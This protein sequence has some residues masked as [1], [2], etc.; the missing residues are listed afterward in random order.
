M[1]Q[2]LA[3]KRFHTAEQAAE[4]ISL[5]QEHDIPT[6]YEEEVVLLDK[7]YSGQNFD[8]RHLVKIPADYFSRA[9]ALLKSQITVSP[10]DVEPDYYLLS[11]STEELKEVII[12]KDEW[13][14]FD[15]ALALKLLEKQ[16]ISYSAEQLAHLGNSRLQTLSEP[17]DL[18]V[19]WLMIGYLSPLLLFVPL[20]YPYILSVMGI[21]IGAFV[22]LTKKTL[23]DGSRIQAFSAKT[24]N[25]GKWMILSGI[26]LTVICWALLIRLMRG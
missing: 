13:G 3:F 4:I 11:F 1:P 15:Y 9:D 21:F 7:M 6:E 16:G 17:Q 20:P 26:V 8:Q 25:H 24:R 2:L 14:D 18:P 19:I 12:K 10:E 22:R 23:P 5:L